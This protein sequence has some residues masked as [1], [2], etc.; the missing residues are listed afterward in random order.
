MNNYITLCQHQ[1]EAHNALE[2]YFEC[3]HSGEMAQASQYLEIHK[4][5]KLAAER[6]EE[7]QLKG[8]KKE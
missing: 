1:N 2:D 6:M 8:K 7:S 5:R 3:L 4:A